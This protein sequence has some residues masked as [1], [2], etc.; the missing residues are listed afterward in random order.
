VTVP[1]APVNVMSHG[2]VLYVFELLIFTLLAWLGFYYAD[3]ELPGLLEA[4]WL[5]A[6]VAIAP[7]V[8]WQ[9]SVWGGEPTFWGE[10]DD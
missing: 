6:L 10:G 2:F 9:W 1:S 5:W 4:P 7:L 3:R 8:P